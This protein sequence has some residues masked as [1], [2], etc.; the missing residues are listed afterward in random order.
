M[1]PFPMS[2]VLRLVRSFLWVVGGGALM[3]IPAASVSIEACGE[4]GS[5]TQLRSTM[6]QN[7]E[8]WD[9]CD[10]TVQNPNDQCIFI[11]GNPKDCTGVLT[12]EFAVNRKY[13]ADAEMAVYTIG[14]QSQGCY[15]CAVPECISGELG[16]CEPVSRR[17]ILVTGF[18]PSGLPIGGLL[19][20]GTTPTGDGASPAVTILDQ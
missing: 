13:R 15:L 2:R 12:C 4:S 16:Y 9:A 14:Q 3:T 10:P 5:C 11:P 6:Y 1:K 17:C 18:T 8:V 20:A 7:K 19:D